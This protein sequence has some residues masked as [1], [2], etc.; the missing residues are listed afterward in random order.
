M[1]SV[2]YFFTALSYVAICAAAFYIYVSWRKGTARGTAERAYDSLPKAVSSAIG[3]LGILF[4]LPLIMNLLWA[5]SVLEPTAQDA[6]LINGALTVTTAAVMLLI[7]YKITGNRNLLYLLALFAITVVSVYSFSRFF[8]SLLLASQLLFLI[9]SLDM[10]I[11]RRYHVQLAGFIGAVYAIINIIFTALLY[12]GIPYTDLYWF[13]PNALLALM[14]FM[15]HLDK[16]YYALLPLWQ[17][18]VTS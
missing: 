6:M 5:F 11:V 2:Y 17:L 15:L 4:L 9:I 16:K 7:I 8:T 1:A 10:A 14:L 13:L 12:F 3:L 18:Y